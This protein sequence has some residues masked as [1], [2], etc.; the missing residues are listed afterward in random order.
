LF[1]DVDFNRNKKKLK[2]KFGLSLLD[3][4]QEAVKGVNEVIQNG[5]HFNNTEKKSFDQLDVL[6]DILK[7][8][9]RKR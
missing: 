8:G 2:L 7:C 1:N 3:F 9:H 6:E 5:S 4:R